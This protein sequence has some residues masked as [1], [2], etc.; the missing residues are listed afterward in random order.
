MML[1]M[2]KMGTDHR[3]NIAILLLIMPMQQKRLIMPPTQQNR[4]T[5]LQMVRVD[6]YP[7]LDMP[8]MPLIMLM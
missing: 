2:M 6:N 5:M 1:Q 7:R 4:S 8:I 3:L